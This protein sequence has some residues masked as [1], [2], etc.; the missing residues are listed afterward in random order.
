MMNQSLDAVVLM[1]CD[2]KSEEG[3]GVAEMSV[4]GLGILNAS[5]VLLTRRSSITTT[6][7][8]TIS[9]ITFFGIR[10]D[11]LKITQVISSLVQSGRGHVENKCK[12]H[13]GI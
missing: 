4:S 9:T 5:F 13:P 7:T 12:Q 6:S 1:K 11:P 10:L 3:A 2:G 8:S